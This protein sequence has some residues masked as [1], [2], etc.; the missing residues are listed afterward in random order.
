[1]RGIPSISLQA[2]QYTPKLAREAYRYSFK[3]VPLNYLS[4][5]WDESGKIRLNLWRDQINK[6]RVGDVVRLENAFINV[7]NYQNELDL[8]KDGKLIVLRR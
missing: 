6:V 8:G 3:L 5:R 2:L 4:D 7:F 1:L